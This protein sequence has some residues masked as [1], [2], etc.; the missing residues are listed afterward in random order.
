MLGGLFSARITRNYCSNF[1]SEEGFVSGIDGP[2]EGI[3][4]WKWWL[5]CGLSDRDC[6]KHSKVQIR[7]RSS[8][9]R[10]VLIN[11][12]SYNQKPF[13]TAYLGHSLVPNRV[14]NAFPGAVLIRLRRD[15]I[16][17]ALSLLQCM[18]KHNKD[19]FS[20][21]PFECDRLQNASEFQRVASQVYWLNRRLDNADWADSALTIHYEKLCENPMKQIDRIRAWCKDR[22][23]TVNFKYN[24]P[25]SFPYKKVDFS[26]NIDAIKI[27][28]ELN[29]L[30]AR[31]GF[32]VRKD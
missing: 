31:H 16:S 6:N 5:G 19:W 23:I 24:L 20:V 10:R 18:R 27:K 3:R 26:T 28:E 2:A 29:I 14:H 11:L 13:A 9:L 17:N 30:E 22:G 15:P 12:R 25:S 21:K 1:M 7:K 32:L 4:F 8:Y